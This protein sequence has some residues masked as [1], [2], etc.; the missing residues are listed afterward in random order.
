MP[1]NIVICCDG[2]NNSLVE[3]VTNI[4]HS[5]RLPDVDVFWKDSLP[6]IRFRS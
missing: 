2:T 4:G 3:P 1:R 6:K 5:S